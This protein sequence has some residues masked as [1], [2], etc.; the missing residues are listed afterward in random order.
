MS[1][2]HIID[3]HMLTLPTNVVAE[4]KLLNYQCPYRNDYKKLKVMSKKF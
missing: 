4:K 2:K 3:E 1:Q